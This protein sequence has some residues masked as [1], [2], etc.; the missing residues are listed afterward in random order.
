M[1]KLLQRIKVYQYL[2]HYWNKK[3]EFKNHSGTKS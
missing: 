3:L 1:R 2:N